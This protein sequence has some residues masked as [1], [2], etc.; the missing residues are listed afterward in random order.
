MDRRKAKSGC[1]VN[2]PMAAFPGLDV[3]DADAVGIIV[4]RS[5]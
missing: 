5:R 1:A 3:M 4:P 2:T